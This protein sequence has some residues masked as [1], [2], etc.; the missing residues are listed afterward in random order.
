MEDFKQRG[1]FISYDSFLTFIAWSQI[2]SPSL[3]AHCH[4]RPAAVAAAAAAAMSRMRLLHWYFPFGVAAFFD[5]IYLD[6]SKNIRFEICDSF[7]HR[8]CT[9]QQ[10]L[11]IDR[12]HK[13]LFR[14]MGKQPYC[15]RR[16]RFI[17]SENF[18]NRKLHIATAIFPNSDLRDISAGGLCC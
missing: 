7:I 1:Y 5:R 11:S 3:E 13:N 12:T 10:C 8:L 16:A 9:L 4:L 17:S 18:A 6:T 2:R 14:H 15:G